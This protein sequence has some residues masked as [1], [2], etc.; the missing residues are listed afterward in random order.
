MPGYHLTLYT[1]GPVFLQGETIKVLCRFAAL[2][3]ERVASTPTVDFRLFYS[4]SEPQRHDQREPLQVPFRPAPL[5]DAPG[6]AATS[7]NSE[8]LEAGAYVVRALDRHP[9]EDRG[10]RET[11][12]FVLSPGTYKDYWTE[13]AEEEFIEDATIDALEGLVACIKDLVNQRLAEK[14]RLNAITMAF[15]LLDRRGEAI[16]SPLRRIRRAPFEWFHHH[17]L[18]AAHNQVFYGGNIAL[19]ILVEQQHLTSSLFLTSYPGGMEER[20]PPFLQYVAS[21]MGL[22]VEWE[23]ERRSEHQ[24]EITCRYPYEG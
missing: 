7:L 4:P 6:L 1:N 8:I 11:E 24:F 16:F 2:D 14:L 21:G 13:L 15:D 17:L 12:F 3:R 18:Q 5:E 20:L 10:L 19:T 23:A 22:P 9:G